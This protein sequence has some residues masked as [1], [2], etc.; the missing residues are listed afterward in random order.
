MS[1]VP[2]FRYAG[3]AEEA[4]YGESPAPDAVFHL[5]IASA[6][7][8]APTETE[9]M[10]EGSIGRGRTKHRPGFYSPSGD[11]V[12]A[13]DV[14]T[15]GWFLKWALGNYVF[16]EGTDPALNT[17]E[18]YR[19]DN[20]IL[21]TFCSRIGKDVF[22]H[23]FSG[24]S[25]NELTLEVSDGFGQLTVDILSQ[26]DGKATLQTISAL[27]LPTEFPLMFHEVTATRDATDVSAKVKSFTLT[28]SNNL[29]AEAG[30]SIGSRYPR[31]LIA[32]AHEVTIEADLF[33]EDSSQL[34]AYWGGSTGPA[35]TGTDEFGMAF[36][37]DAGTD[38]QIEIAAPRVIYN[39]VPTQPSGRDELTQSVSMA[40]YETEHTLADGTTKVNSELLVTVTNNVDEMKAAA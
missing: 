26:K 16:T 39:E 6:S 31:R 12:V 18:I 9:M 1:G 20:N 19:S 34:E 2:I 8:D 25:I 5:D 21:P 36:V 37:L 38:G 29:D 15:A 7:L 30:R 22:E 33:Y 28:I 32:S 27:I 24:C 10:F 40:P 3:F 35:D 17:H 23:V 4:T 11:V 13:I 14:R